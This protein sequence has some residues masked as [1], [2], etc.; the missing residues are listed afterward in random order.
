MPHFKGREN[1]VFIIFMIGMVTFE[2]LSS[3]TAIQSRDIGRGLPPPMS[4]K[5]I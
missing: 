3:V 2:V 1:R 4:A 5:A